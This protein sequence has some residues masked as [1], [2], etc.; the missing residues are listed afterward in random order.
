MPETVLGPL[1]VPL[2]D[3]QLAAEAL[4]ALLR[5][6]HLEQALAAPGLVLA[7]G[8]A[9]LAVLGLQ[10]PVLL[11][12]AA[13]RRVREALHPQALLVDGEQARL[14]PLL[15]R[16]ELRLRP[17][18][19]PLNLRPPP[20][21]SRGVVL[22]ANMRKLCIRPDTLALRAPRLLHLATQHL[23]L[24]GV[25]EAQARGLLQGLPKLRLDLLRALPGH[26]PQFTVTSSGR[27]EGGGRE[28]DSFFFG[29]SLA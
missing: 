29:R 7:E 21:F 20:P 10:R 19:L 8:A 16:L 24:G 1:E 18:E 14:D 9:G 13:H 3:G 17:L 11:A 23:E 28:S 5:A 12:Q 22:S 6:Q 2:R 27:G 15:R 26:A 4:H 25:L